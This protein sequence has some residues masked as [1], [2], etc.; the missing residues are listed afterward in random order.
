MEKEGEFQNPL[1]PPA[2]LGRDEQEVAG[3][4]HSIIWM[5]VASNVS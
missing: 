2:R 4:G 1:L 5:S 3:G